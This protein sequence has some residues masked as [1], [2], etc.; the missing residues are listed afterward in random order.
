MTYQVFVAMDAKIRR[1]LC[2]NV[3]P[4]LADVPKELCQDDNVLF[5]WSMVSAD[6]DEDESEALLSMVADLWVT[7]RG[8]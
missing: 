2:S 4:N 7:I 8:F 3:P 6:W 1:H 5:Y